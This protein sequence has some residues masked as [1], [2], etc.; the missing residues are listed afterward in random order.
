MRIF[1]DAENR[2]WSVDITVG[3]LRRIRELSGIN[4][5]TPAALANG[6]TMGR[7]SD[8]LVLLSDV[9]Y[10]AVKPQADA[11]GL[12]KEQYTDAIR[13]DAINDGTYALLYAL[14]DFFPKVQGQLFARLLDASKEAQAKAIEDAEKAVQSATERLTQ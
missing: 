4:L 9:L 11:K 7:L 5:A 3:T 1:K 8:D 6:D 14:A 2:E 10:A 13:G 12:D